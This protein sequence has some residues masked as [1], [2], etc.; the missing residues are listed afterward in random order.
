[1][2]EKTLEDVVKNS[3]SVYD[4]KFWNRHLKDFQRWD[5][6]KSGMSASKAFAVVCGWIMKMKI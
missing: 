6:Q 5:E 4:G 2:K 3:N 1:M